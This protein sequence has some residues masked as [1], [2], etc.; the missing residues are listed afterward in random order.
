MTNVIA[1]CSNCTNITCLACSGGLYL[2]INS[3]SCILNC[4]AAESSKLSNLYII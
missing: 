2:A 1:N 3:K 4:T